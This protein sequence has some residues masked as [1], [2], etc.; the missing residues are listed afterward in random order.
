M[1]DGVGSG[2]DDGLVE[3]LMDL[4]SLPVCQALRQEARILTAYMSEVEASS[5]LIL[6]SSSLSLFLFLTLP[7]FSPRCLPPS[8]ERR[9]VFLRL[10]VL[11]RSILRTRVAGA[12]LYPTPTANEC[13]PARFSSL[14]I[15]R[16][17]PFTATA[18]AVAATA[19]AT[20]AAAVTASAVPL[21]RPFTR[22]P[23]RRTRCDPPYPTSCTNS[24]SPTGRS[25][26]RFP[27]V[28]SDA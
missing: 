26:L 16:S 17:Q 19:A 25:S 6:L 21:C 14:A 27:R 5:S 10:G 24:S 1:R 23:D 20:A 7:L 3:P 28:E 9:D 12:E 2:S 18:V 4:K 15:P 22:T 8:R 13:P 11:S